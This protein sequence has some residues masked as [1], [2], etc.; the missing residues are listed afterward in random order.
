MTIRHATAMTLCAR[1]SCIPNSHITRSHLLGSFAA[2]PRANTCDSLEQRL[3]GQYGDVFFHLFDATTP[4]WRTRQDYPHHQLFSR[5]TDY[6]ALAAWT[7]SGVNPSMLNSAIQAKLHAL[8][9]GSKCVILH[10]QL[11]RRI[12]GDAAYENE[13]FTRITDWFAFDAARSDAVVPNASAALAQAVVIGA[14]GQIANAFS[15]NPGCGRIITSKKN[16]NFWDKRSELH[17]YYMSLRSKSPAPAL[18]APLRAE[19]I[20]R[21]LGDTIDGVSIDE[22]LAAAPNAVIG[23]WGL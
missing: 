9:A 17:R 8:P 6:A 1:K 3:C 16:F 19:G 5:E 22:M 10:P 23:V 20:S 13:I 11:S 2:S 7:P 18:C 21:V 15:C 12:G 14:D 4:Y